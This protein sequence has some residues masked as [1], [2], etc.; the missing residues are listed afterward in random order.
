MKRNAFTKYGGTITDMK[1]TRR[2]LGGS[3]F[4]LEIKFPSVT[5]IKNPAKGFFYLFPLK[6]GV[7][8][9]PYSV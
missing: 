2:F 4:L 5:G 3:T 9:C 6:Y 7:E 8:V 1:L